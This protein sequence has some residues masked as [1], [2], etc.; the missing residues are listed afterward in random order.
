MNLLVNI[1]SRLL[2]TNQLKTRTTKQ[3]IDGAI[4]R[5]K[6]GR[7]EYLACKARHESAKKETPVDSE[8]RAKATE[9]AEKKRIHDENLGK[10]RLE[11]MEKRQAHERYIVKVKAELS[12]KFK[13]KT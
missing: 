10:I 12:A 8:I 3:R 2:L 6:S 1:T 9:A 13:A 7:E 4:A 5:K 11:R